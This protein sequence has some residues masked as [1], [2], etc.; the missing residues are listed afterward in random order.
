M[1]RDIKDLLDCSIVATD[2]IVG[3][4]KDLYFDDEAWVIR[5]FVVETGNWLLQRRVLISPLAVTA[6]AVTPGVLPVSLTKAQVKDSPGIDTDEPV[7]RQHEREYLRYYGYPFYWDGGGLWG[8][9]AAHPGSLLT[10]LDQEGAAAGRRR[11]QEEDRRA[12]AEADA[13]LLQHGDHHLRSAKIVMAYYVHA[14]DGE[15]GH[16]KGFLIEQTTWAVR[17][18]IVT[19]SDW[20]QGHD[21]LISPEWIDEV[22]WD[23]NRVLVSLTRSA[24]KSALEY[25]SHLPLDRDHEKDLY[26]HHGQPPYW[27][28]EVEVQHPEFQGNPAE[29]SAS[30]QKVE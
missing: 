12:D 2:G 1:L 6:P 16:V 28:R 30:R 10:G 29:D 19:T 22:R 3:T 26:A 18:M 14:S 23:D 11:S 25:K 8:R 13:E 21:V 4:I 24:V 5:Y 9:S 7:S 15:I 20:W 27:A 17:Y